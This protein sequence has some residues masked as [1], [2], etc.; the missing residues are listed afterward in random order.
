MKT[1]LK[2]SNPTELYKSIQSSVK[3]SC[4]KHKSLIKEINRY[5]LN[6][7]DVDILFQ[8]IGDD[9]EIR[10]NRLQRG[11]ENRI[12]VI[13]AMKQSRFEPVQLIIDTGLIK[14]LD[15]LDKAGTPA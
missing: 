15:K 9:E 7:E 6:I 3:R 8:T 12:S 11:K 5:K 2:V 14:E 4:V 13:V 1:K 10:Y